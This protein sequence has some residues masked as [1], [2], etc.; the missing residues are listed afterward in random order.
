MISHK[1]RHQFYKVCH[2]AA[3]EIWCLHRVLPIRSI[4][5]SNRELE[6]TPDF[7][8]SLIRKYIHNG[9]KFVDIDT[10]STHTSLLPQKQVNVSFDDGFADIYT[11]AFPIFQKYKIPFTIYLTS[12]LPEGKADLWW[13][14]LEKI[15]N[16]N[17]DFFESTIKNIYS[18]D[19]PMSQRMHQLTLSEPDYTITQQLSLSWKEILEMVNSGLCT[20]GSHTIS[21][22]GLTR[23]PLE[24]AKMEILDSK[25]IIE[26]KLTG[27]NI[28]IKHFSY[29]HSM[30]NTEILDILRQSPYTTAVLGYGGYI[31]VRTNKFLLNRKYIVQD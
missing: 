12:D 11:Y 22:P 26:S 14:Q 21:H 6:I 16:G 7:L 29:P 27:C 4:F 30:Y 17:I 31:R 10:I 5:P 20:I 15:A 1:I 24:M 25:R 3:G 28:Q 2:P 19:Q 8:E 13:C 23:I 18:S 9:Y